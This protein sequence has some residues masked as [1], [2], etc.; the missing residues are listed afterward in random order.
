MVDP[1]HHPGCVH[2]CVHVCVRVHMGE[3]VV[4][5]CVHAND[6][7]YVHV[8]VCVP[9]QGKNSLRKTA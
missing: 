4:R 2:M 7:M 6:G 9:P 8:S 5:M 3:C 1:S